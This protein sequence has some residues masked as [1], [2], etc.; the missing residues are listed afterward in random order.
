MV[1]A[2]MGY[3]KKEIMH[4]ITRDLLVS[5]SA[6][7]TI[8]GIVYVFLITRYR[9]RMSMLEKGINPSSF[10]PKP[11]TSYTLKLGMLSVGIALGILAG[12]LLHRTDMLE[13]APSYF[14]MIFLFGGL[15]L[16]VNFII[17]RKLKA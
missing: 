15:S 17:D 5:L 10:N 6:F 7:A 12:N 3:T 13:R 16:I 2:H 8:F 1:S 14:A 4:E 9:E 11:G